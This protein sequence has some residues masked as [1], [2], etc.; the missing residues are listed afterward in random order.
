LLDRLNIRITVLTP[1]NALDTRDQSGGNVRMSPIGSFRFGEFTLHPST[2]L[3]CRRDEAIALPGKAFD[4]MAYLIEHRNRAVGRDELTSAVWGR[5]DVSDSVLNQTILHARRALGVGGRAQ[6]VIRTV[7]G[8]GYH[9]IAPIEIVEPTAVV[10]AARD[11]AQVVAKRPLAARRAGVIA[12]LV[13]L[14]T[15]ALIGSRHRIETAGGERRTRHALVVLPVETDSDAESAWLRL[16][17]MDLVA[18]RLR[19]TGAPVVPSDSVVALARA[20]D[21]SDAADVAR[22]SAAAA[23]DVV[24]KSRVTR[25]NGRWLVEVRTASGR[26]PALIAQGRGDN[27][28]EAGSAAADAIAAKLGLSPAAPLRVSGGDLPMRELLQQVKAAT[29]N[30]RLDDARRLVEQASPAQRQDPELAFRLAKI[31]AQAGRVG[32]AADDLRALLDRVGAERDPVLRARIL[33]ALGVIALQRSDAAAAESLHGQAIGLLADAGNEGQLGKSYADR[34]AARFALDRD[35]DALGDVAKARA[36]LENVGDRL[37]LTFLDGN[38]GAIEMKR[39]RY[40]EAAPVLEDVAARFDALRI[41]Y[42]ALNEWDAAAQ[43]HL[44]LLE[45]SAA[46]KIEPRL[47]TLSEVVADPRL[48]F[49][50]GLTRVEIVAGAGSMRQARQLLDQL[51]TEYAANATPELIGRADAIDA[52]LAFSA[53]EFAAASAA[54]DAAFSAPTEADDAR[55]HERNWLTLVRAQILTDKLASAARSVQRIATLAAHGTPSAARLYLGLARAEFARANRDDAAAHDAYEKAFA[56]AESSR[57]PLDILEAADAYGNWLIETHDLA[58]ASSVVERVAPW[59]KQSYEAS[60][61]QLRLYHA[62]QLASAWSAS[63]ERTRA[64]AGERR[65]PD[66]LSAWP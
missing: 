1:R 51:R 24:L 53:G 45:P 23:A 29:L 10:P 62:A 19:A 57:V 15:L 11:A 64:L 25:D 43:S 28:L 4:C 12:A 35:D 38:M 18:E 34:A 26:E 55:E 27:A 42:A 30:D 9:W 5:V 44:I 63:L 36:A 41:H 31:D 17:L 40:R 48:R 66:E 22:L 32:E 39:G 3:L 50:T 7:V 46:A 37:S 52:R 58:R 47:R 60:L 14:A 8:F 59:A 54:A 13:L 61:L 65:I 16:G 33:D 2:R 20:F 6:N 21:T 49:G 56:E